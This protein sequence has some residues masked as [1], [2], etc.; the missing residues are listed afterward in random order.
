MRE[1]ALFAQL[2]GS[3]VASICPD[4][5]A[6]HSDSPGCSMAPC[7]DD[8]TYSEGYVAF[9]SWFEVTAERLFIAQDIT[10]MLMYSILFCM[11]KHYL[12]TR[13]LHGSI[14]LVKKSG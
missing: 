11:T 1:T 13:A 3:T 6:Y 10:D 9:P 8:T 4:S 7:H 5:E 14:H 2:V 12:Y